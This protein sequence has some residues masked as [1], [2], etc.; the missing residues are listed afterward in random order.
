MP[1]ITKAELD[2]LRAKADEAENLRKE[3]EALKARKP[4]KTGG[5][6]R[7]VQTPST[8]TLRASWDN[9]GGFI[10]NFDKIVQTTQEATKAAYD[11]KRAFIVFTAENPNWEKAGQRTAINR[12][13]TNLAKEVANT[14]VA[15]FRAIKG[16]FD[17]IGLIQREADGI[18]QIARNC[19]V[20]DNTGWITVFEELTGVSNQRLLYGDKG[21]KPTRDVRERVE[22]TL[23]DICFGLPERVKGSVSDFL[24]NWFKK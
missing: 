12:K 20:P 21:N 3:N 14:Q 5:T 9:L 1:S 8:A 23:K 10:A 13:G 16:Y 19:R 6:G 22:S 4:V 7:K 2:A 17:G 15:A 11:A 18:Y 24:R